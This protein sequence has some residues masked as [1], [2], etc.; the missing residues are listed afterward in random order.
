MREDSFTVDKSFMLGLIPDEKIKRNAPGLIE[1]YNCK[2]NKHGVDFYSPILNPFV[3][4]PTVTW[5][6]PQIF[7]AVDGIYI[8]T[9]TAIYKANAYYVCSPVITGIPAGN[10][11]NL[12]DFMVFQ[13]WTNGVVMVVRD[14]ETG[15]FAIYPLEHTVETLCNYNGQLITANFGDE[16]DN[17]VAWGGIGKVDL[18]HLLYKEDRS[19]TTGS[20]PMKFRGDIYQVKVL[21][22]KIMVY[23][24]RGISAIKPGSIKPYKTMAQYG[25]EDIFNFGIAGKGCVGGD[26]NIHVF[27]DNYGYVHA[28]DKA[29]KHHE[30]GYSNYIANFE[31]EI[32]ITHDPLKGEYYV[33]DGNKCYV[34]SAGLTEVYQCPAGLVREGAALYGVTYDNADTSAYVTTNSFN[35]FTDSIKTAQTVEAMITGVDLQ[36]AIDYKFQ[37]SE[38]F[39]RGMLKNLS[40]HG[41]FTPMISGV[42]MRLHLKASSYVGFTVDSAI[43]RYKL[44]DKRT[45]RGPYAQPTDL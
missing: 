31:N 45:I 42:D 23:G 4:L 10:L 24:A 20:M 39:S 3:G 18:D 40:R 5:P 35:M 36:G 8:A 19:N 37:P 33:S 15:Q 25:R 26:E 9:Q 1:A 13:I 12:A 27:I 44:S 30:L 7:N 21:G 2:V 14:G 16:K 11:W 38:S 29:G 17:W 32:S 34:F 43:V 22:D 6:Y 41:A 28:L